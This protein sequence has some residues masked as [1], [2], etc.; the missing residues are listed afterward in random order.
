VG[1]NGCFSLREKY[2]LRV[3]ENKVLRIFVP[4]R[5]EVESNIKNYVKSKCVIF[6]P[7]ILLQ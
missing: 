1:T 5:D 7:V 6:T 2:A 4:R 3:F